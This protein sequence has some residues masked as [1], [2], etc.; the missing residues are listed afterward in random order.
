MAPLHVLDPPDT[1]VD[2]LRAVWPFSCSVQK[3]RFS[4]SMHRIGFRPSLAETLAEWPIVLPEWP[5]TSTCMRARSE[6]NALSGEKTSRDTE[7]KYQ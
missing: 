1:G 3:L 2:Q 4:L 5:A 7:T 6:T